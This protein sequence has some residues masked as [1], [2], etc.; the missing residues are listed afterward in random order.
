[1]IAA[2]NPMTKTIAE[3]ENRLAADL[4]A[5]GYPGLSYLK[6]QR[7]TRTPA[8]LLLAALRQENLDSRL[9]E[10]LPWLIWQFVDL[11]WKWLAQMAQTNQLQNRLG[12]VISLARRLAEQHGEQDKVTLLAQVEAELESA[13][14][15]QE[16]TLCHASLTQAERTWL[17]HHRP[18][19]ARHWRLLTDLTAEHLDYAA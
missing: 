17:H 18:Q 13:R 9:V 14:L 5:I 4:A 10:A 3:E 16:D 2:M 12:F 8:E 7:A 6:S 11:D 19:T 15:P 1:M